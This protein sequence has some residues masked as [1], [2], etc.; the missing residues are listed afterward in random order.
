MIVDDGLW[1]DAH[2]CA[3]MACHEHDMATC[4]GA[5]AR[6]AGATQDAREAASGARASELRARAGLWPQARLLRTLVGQSS[7]RAP[8]LGN[9]TGPRV[10]P[11]QAAGGWPRRAVQAVPGYE[12]D[13]GSLP[14]REG[15]GREEGEYSPF[16]APPSDSDTM[17]GDEGQSRA[18][19]GQF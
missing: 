4:T 14:W 6:H 15:V 7:T 8:E 19:V 2:T 9:C 5:G 16:S 3:T 10:T 13:G 11:D 18:D 1:R 17:E 12:H